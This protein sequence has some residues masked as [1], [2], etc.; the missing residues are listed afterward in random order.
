MKWFRNALIRFLLAW[1]ILISI[2]GGLPTS[3]A[4]EI[5]PRA[6]QDYVVTHPNAT[7]AEIQE[8]AASQSPEFAG[9]YKNGAE[10]LAIIR[11]DKT[12]L[13]DNMYDFFKHWVWHILSWPDH[14]LFVLSLLLVFVSWKEI[15][16]L[17]WVFTLAH[18]I[19][20]ILAWTGILVLSSRIVEPMIAL[21]IAYVAFTSVFL[22]SWWFFWNNTSKI[23]AIFFFGLFHGLWFA[24]LLQ[25]INIPQDKFISSLLAFNL[26]IEGGQL[27]IVGIAFPF[28]YFLKDLKI[29][30]ILIKIFSTLIIA[31]ALYWFFERIMSK[32]IPGL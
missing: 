4:H 23:F 32:S 28:I 30:E 22:R 24:W 27:I 13:I 19:T 18:S 9:K 11:N 16:K 12:S 29:Y 17:T 2:F 10:I 3:L 7:P 21:S 6:L 8:F 31:I 1:L 20:L 5:I 15:L 26:G 25:E 14:I